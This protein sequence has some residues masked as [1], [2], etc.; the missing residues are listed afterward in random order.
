MLGGLLGNTLV[1]PEEG[2]SAGAGHGGRCRV[3]LLAVGGAGTVV[4]SDE[5]LSGL[6]DSLGVLGGHG[7]AVLGS[8]DTDGLEWVS[9]KYI[10]NGREPMA[11]LVVGIAG[12]LYSTE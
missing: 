7:N 6:L 4:H 8:L 12:V 3:A 9:H 1:D 11:Y 5:G 2:R 10:S